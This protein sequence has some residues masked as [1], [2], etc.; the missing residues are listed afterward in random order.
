MAAN[1]VY[2]H[3]TEVSNR[4][5]EWTFLFLCVNLLI[6]ALFIHSFIRLPRKT[7]MERYVFQFH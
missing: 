4:H 3:Q 2:G 7:D 5:T 1:V 6:H